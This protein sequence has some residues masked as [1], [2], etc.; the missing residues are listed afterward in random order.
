MVF[1]NPTRFLQPAG[2]MV[3]L[4][5][6]LEMRMPAPMTCLRIGALSRPLLLSALC[7]FG[8][9]LACP[10]VEAQRGGPPRR[11]ENPKDLTLP[12]KSR[13]EF[14][15]Y[16]SSALGLDVDYSVLLPPSYDEESDRKFPIVYFLHGLNNDHTSWAT[17]RYGDLP[18]RIDLLMSQG[19][20]PHFV[21]V[22]PD[23]Q[24]SLYTDSPDGTGSYES[25][26]RGDLV[27][28]M[29]ERYR[30]RADAAGR[31]IG[32]VSMGG[33]GALKIAMKHS[34]LYASAAGVSPIVFLGEDP[35]VSLR[36]NPSRRSAYFLRLVEKAFG[37][38]MDQGHWKQNSLE[39]LARTVSLAG[40]NLYFSYG[41]AD[42]YNRLFPMEQGVKSLA[43]IL[44]ERGISHQ[45][46]I[47]EGEP[48]GWELVAGHLEETLA[49]LTQTF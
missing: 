13:L 17:P 26:I 40:L 27:Q 32:G 47:F 4:D 25:S 35:F 21:M 29:Q 31:A 20:L 5:S 36:S 16:R 44:Q 7:S 42:R 15:S 41:T 9:L 3:K 38:P 33:Y 8:L 49:F 1:K 23:G 28:K 6:S 30:V 39:V 48:H 24:N 11:L 14:R 2:K 45:C 12:N 10:V 34:G 37:N 22:H 18:A 19:K 43:R 46:M